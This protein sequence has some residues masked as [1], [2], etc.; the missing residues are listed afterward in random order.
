MPWEPYST[1]NPGTGRAVYFADAPPLSSVGISFAAGDLVICTDTTTGNPVMWRCISSGDPG[2]WES[3]GESLLQVNFNVIGGA[4]AADYDGGVIMRGAWELVAVTERHQTAG[5]DAG[6]VTL[7]VVKAASGTAKGSGTNMLASGINLKASANTNQSGTPHA[8]AANRQVAD[9]DLVG[10]STT[11]TLT[12]V[13]G[14]TVTCY[15]K[16]I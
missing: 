10:L 5:T 2:T 15:F 16:R 6:A 13:D 14:V 3:V 12:A 11:G 8:T 4:N 1:I 9:G 7:Q